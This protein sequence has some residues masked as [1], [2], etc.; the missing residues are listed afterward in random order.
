MERKDFPI[1]WVDE[2]YGFLY[3]KPYKF[4]LEEAGFIIESLELDLSNTKSVIDHLDGKR[5]LALHVG[6][7]VVRDSI[8]G[9]L[10]EVE[11]IGYVII[12]ALT[13]GFINQHWSEEELKLLDYNLYVEAISPE[14]CVE[15]FQD[16]INKETA[17]GR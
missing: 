3:F 12:V 1:L 14:D 2:G 11:R 10:N 7:L 16:I 15:F 17:A 4:L 13:L 8:I 5:I 9:L 6:S